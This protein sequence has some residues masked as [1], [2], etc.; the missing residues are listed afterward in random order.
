MQ[1]LPAERRRPEAPQRAG[2]ARPRRGDDGRGLRRDTPLREA[3]ILALGDTVAAGKEGLKE[4]R[5]AQLRKYLRAL[6]LST[7]PGREDHI[8]SGMRDVIDNP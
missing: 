1:S 3:L 5:Q 7:Y 8:V 6:E 4:L 2:L